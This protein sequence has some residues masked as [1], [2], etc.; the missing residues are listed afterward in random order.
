MSRCLGDLHYKRKD[1]LSYEEQAVTYLPDI[2]KNELTTDDDFL[3]MGCDGVWERYE[4]DSQGLIDRIR[5]ERMKGNKPEEVMEKLL[6]SF[7]SPDPAKEQLGCDNMSAILIEFN[8][9]AI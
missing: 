4:N 5:E 1:S 8:K 3:I 6:D 2:T 9:L 7:L